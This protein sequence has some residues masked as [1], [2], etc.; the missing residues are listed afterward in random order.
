MVSE[1]K[2]QFHDL[3]TEPTGIPTNG[4]F[5]IRLDHSAKEPFRTPYRLTPKEEEELEK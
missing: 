3:F 5:R 2:T 4:N 1:I